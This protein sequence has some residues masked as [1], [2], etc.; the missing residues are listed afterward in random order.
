M[1]ATSLTTGSAGDVTHY[2]D[3]ASDAKAHGIFGGGLDFGMQDVTTFWHG[4]FDM[5]VDVSYWGSIGQSSSLA[6]AGQVRSTQV[7]RAE[8][9]GLWHRDESRWKFG[10][11]I[12]GRQENDNSSPDTADSFSTKYLW[13]SPGFHIQYAKT[14]LKLI[15]SVYSST[16]DIDQY[17]GTSVSSSNLVLNL[18]SC[19]KLAKIV[20][21]EFDICGLADY[22]ILKVNGAGTPAQPVFVTSPTYSYSSWSLGVEFKL[23]GITF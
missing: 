13:I 23:L 17:R 8:I 1:G 3:L 12:D 7:L 5:A 16:L 4:F 14:T 9:E 18:E 15:K 6:T 21:G 19:R 11:I 20:K 22:Q 10:L 2:T